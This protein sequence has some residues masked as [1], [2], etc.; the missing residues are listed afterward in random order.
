[1]CKHARAKLNLTSKLD[2][3]QAARPPDYSGQLTPSHEV[4]VIVQF[5]MY[6]ARIVVKIQKI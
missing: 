6:I 1:M 5:I 2:P 3:A 4:Y